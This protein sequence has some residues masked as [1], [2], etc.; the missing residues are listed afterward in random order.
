MLFSQSLSYTIYIQHTTPGISYQLLVVT[1]RKPVK[2]SRKN[3]ITIKKNNKHRRKGRRQQKN[4]TKESQERLASK[5][6]SASSKFVIIIETG[7]KDEF[8]NRQFLEGCGPY[9]LGYL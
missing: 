2:N 3:I 6:S 8:I 4:A 7:Q 9:L 5:R 1:L